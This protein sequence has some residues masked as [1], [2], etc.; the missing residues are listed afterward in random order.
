MMLS[1]LFLRCVLL[2]SST[3]TVK[4]PER[5]AEPERNLLSLKSTN[6]V[7]F[8]FVLGSPCQMDA[9]RLTNAPRIQRV[10]TKQQ[11][12]NQQD[13][14]KL[15]YNV[16][17]LKVCKFIRSYKELGTISVKFCPVLV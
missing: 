10:P 8:S 16:K 1:L 14:T 5:Y 2:S 15:A 12:L 9:H 3:I 7:A 17:A 6:E 13:I 4:D 11:N